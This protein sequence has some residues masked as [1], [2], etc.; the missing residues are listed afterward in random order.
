MITYQIASGKRVLHRLY[1][2]DCHLFRQERFAA[3]I[4][5]RQQS[6]LNVP[7]QVLET[8]NKPKT[9]GV[10]VMWKTELLL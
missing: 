9:L 8:K 6:R 1:Y 4:L 5:H 7:F 3:K 10:V 2:S